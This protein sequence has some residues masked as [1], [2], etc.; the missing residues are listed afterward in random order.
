MSIRRKLKTLFN[1]IKYKLLEK[2]Y[3]T[4]QGR[5][6]YLYFSNNKFDSL[7]ICFSAFPPNEKPLYNYVNSLSSLQMDRLYISD[8]W[9]YRAS[10]YLF[11]DGEQTPYIVTKKL[12]DKILQSKE[13]KHVYT[14]GT[15]KGGTAAI[16]YGLIYNVDAIFSGACQYFIGR[17]LNIPAHIKVLERMMGETV[18][19]P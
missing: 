14:A 7:L 8:S 16:Y 5:A 9:G 6:K 2:E 12:I 13:Y 1:A 19:K 15:S 10:Y 17:Y 4:Q 11:E 3:L 18:R